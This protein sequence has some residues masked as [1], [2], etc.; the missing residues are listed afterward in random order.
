MKGLLLEVE[1]TT[2]SNQMDLDQDIQVINQKTR[3]SE[4]RRGTNGGC[5]NTDIPV[6]VQ[7]L[8]YGS[9]TERVGAYIKPLD[10]HHELISSSE[11]VH[12]TQKD[13]ETS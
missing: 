2:S 1:V 12:D 4:Q 10:R 13:R 3:M 6:S 9:K 8:A 11:V 7:E 5:S